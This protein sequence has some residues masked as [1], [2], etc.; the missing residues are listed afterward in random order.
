MHIGM[1]PHHSLSASRSRDATERVTRID[2]GAAAMSRSA[3]P[4]VARLSPPVI[5]RLH[6]LRP[7]LLDRR[8]SGGSKRATIVLAGPGYG[9]TALLARF[10]QQTREDSVWYSLGPLDRDLSV[11]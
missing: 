7:R 6:L 11:R 5:G 4:P 9:K 3:T 8:R 10:L 1:F 2:G